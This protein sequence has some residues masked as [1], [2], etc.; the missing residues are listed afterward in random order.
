MTLIWLTKLVAPNTTRETRILV[1]LD[2][3]CFIEESRTSSVLW[4]VGEGASLSVEESL[5]Y[6]VEALRARSIKQVIQP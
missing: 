6:I 4:F 2:Q 5:D 3:V 1:N